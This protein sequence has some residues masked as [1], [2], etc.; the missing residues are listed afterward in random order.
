MPVL[1]DCWDLN[2]DADAVLRGQGADPQVIRARKPRLYEIAAQAAAEG[3]PLVRPQVVF[4]RYRVD[5]I[6]HARVNLAGGSSLKGDLIARHLAAA[7]EILA[8]VCTIGPELEELANQVMETEMVHGIALYGVGSAAVEGLANAACRQ[9]ELEAAQRGWKTSIPLSPGMVGWSVEE[10][11]EQ[12]FAL[13]D[14]RQIGVQITEAKIMLPMKSL[15]MALGLGPELNRE[16][17]T[18]DY[19]AMREVCKYQDHYAKAGV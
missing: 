14:S 19:C 12:I 7:E 11:Q 17:S 18:C 3:L 10:G 9:F 6:R 16:G 2:V 5:S 15:S 1:S 4:E 13:L 8:V